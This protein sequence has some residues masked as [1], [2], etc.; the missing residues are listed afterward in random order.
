MIT[1]GYV[2]VLALVQAAMVVW[3]AMTR[4]HEKVSLGTGDSEA[5]EQRTRVYGNFTE[6][7]PMALLLML[8]SEIGGGPLWAIHWMGALLI[9]SRLSHAKGLLTP[10]GYGGYRKAGMLFALAVFL[11]GS[12]LC[13]TLAVQ[14]L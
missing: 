14:S 8:V 13:I 7:V 4:M 2:A 1:G 5:L 11:I 12:V 9:L 6:I 10:P 3:I